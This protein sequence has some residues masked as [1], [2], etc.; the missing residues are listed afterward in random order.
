MSV[1][2]EEIPTDPITFRSNQP[3]KQSNENSE[4]DETLGYISTPFTS[5]KS[6][7]DTTSRRDIDFD[8][9]NPFANKPD[10]EGS[11]EGEYSR[12]EPHHA[13]SNTASTVWKIPLAYEDGI[14]IQDNGK[15]QSDINPFCKD[16][17]EHA[18]SPFFPTLEDA[19]ATRT[20]ESQTQ[21]DF[22][23]MQN[24]L[25]QRIKELEKREAITIEMGDKHAQG[26]QYPEVKNWP[27]F[28]AWTHLNSCFYQNISDDIPK[29]YQDIATRTYHS[30]LVYITLLILNMIVGFVCLMVKIGD[31]DQ[32]MV[33][34]SFGLSILYCLIFV[35]S[36]YLCWFR[37]AYNAFKFDSSARYMTFFFLSFFQCILCLTFA[38]GYGYVGFFGIVNGINE[39][40]CSM[41]NGKDFFV[42]ACMTILGVA[43]SLCGVFQIYAT[44]KINNIYTRKDK[45][46]YEGSKMKDKK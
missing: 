40:I 24:N 1:C 44:I 21:I 17:T 13:L 6:D 10:F 46:P 27:S 7:N 28:P 37:M 35:P 11:M 3:R 8:E 14:I 33:G 30:W 42:G 45:N 9:A 43:F 22:T 5:E 26:T 25:E 2:K 12:N 16:N 34:K 36:S 41:C 32:S 31:E 4:N 19:P 38:L 39:F 20:V 15:Y 23:T 29:A 18:D